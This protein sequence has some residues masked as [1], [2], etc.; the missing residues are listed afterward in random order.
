MRYIC[1]RFALFK[2]INHLYNYDR[3]ENSITRFSQ[4]SVTYLDFSILSLSLLTFKSI[5]K[6]KK[7]HFSKTFYKAKLDANGSMCS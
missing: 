3:P 6:L 7:K 4:T 2:K 5:S 1:I